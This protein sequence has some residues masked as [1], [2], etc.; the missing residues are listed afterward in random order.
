MNMDN[1]NPFIL[2]DWWEVEISPLSSK[3]QENLEY[4]KYCLNYKGVVP[5][6]NSDSDSDSD[7]PADPIIMETIKICRIWHTG[8]NSDISVQILMDTMYPFSFYIK[9]VSEKRSKLK[10][11][12]ELDSV[13]VNAP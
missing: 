2:S 9:I 13:S 6:T 1:I 3:L 4:L 8:S 11:E 7:I 5:L 12:S 10:S